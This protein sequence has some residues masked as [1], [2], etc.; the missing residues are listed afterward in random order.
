MSKFN[1]FTL[2]PHIIAQLEGVCEEKARWLCEARLNPSF[3]LEMAAAILGPDMSK[4]F[5]H[6]VFSF[7]RPP[8]RQTK[9][10]IFT[11]NYHHLIEMRGMDEYMCMALC[12]ARRSEDFDVDAAFEIL[13]P[14]FSRERIL[15]KFSFVR[16][17]PCLHLKGASVHTDSDRSTLS[18]APMSPSPSIS[19]ESPSP[20]VTSR[21]ADRHQYSF[22]R[23]IEQTGASCLPG[24]SIRFPGRKAGQS[25]AYR[26]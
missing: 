5:I 22:S 9:M 25:K 18:V 17:R 20:K 10:N 14:S 21:R 8:P 13:K 4:E 12:K 11:A 1:I 6:E 19:H 15:R 2:A 23:S 7:E 16:K 3:N 26:F 24:D